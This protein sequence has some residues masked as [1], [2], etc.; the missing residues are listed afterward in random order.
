MLILRCTHSLSNVSI[1]GDMVGPTEE[2]R[3]KMTLEEVT[4]HLLCW[5]IASA[6]LE[7]PAPSQLWKA[8]VQH[9][10]LYCS[11]GIGM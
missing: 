9:L 6:N 11:A 4:I 2:E 10:Y 3:R 7:G 1:Q 5:L 8:L